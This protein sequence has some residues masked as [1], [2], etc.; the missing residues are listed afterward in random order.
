MKA[1]IIAA[2]RGKRMKKVTEEIPK[3]L[4][5]I[6]GRPLMEIQLEILRSLGIFDVNVIKGYKKEKIS[7][8]EVKYFINDDYLNNNI[9]ESLFYA[10]EVIYGEVIIHYCDIIFEKSIVMRLM[11][12]DADISIVVDVDWQE[13]YRDRKDHPI[14]EAE[15]VIFDKNYC[16][17]QIGKIIDGDKYSISGEFIGMVKLSDRGAKTLR[18]V[19]WES[20]DKYA[21][22]KFQK[23]ESFKKAYL[24]DIFQEMV[25][26][27]F[28]I[29]CVPIR[30]GW[31]EIDTEEDFNKAACFWENMIK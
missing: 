8:P 11:E 4:L 31:Q 20:R 23:A 19:Y 6:A 10:E 2:G 27:D 12:S 1:I 14:D 5:P 26:N 22:R 7:F 24:T 28:K 3:C 18:K 21:Y 15:N 9:L 30:N 16:V 25:D 17:Q 13:N 29:K